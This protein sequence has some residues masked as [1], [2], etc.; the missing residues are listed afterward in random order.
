MSRILFEQSCK[1]AF[2]ESAHAWVVRVWMHVWLGCIACVCCILLCFVVCCVCPSLCVCVYVHVFCFVVCCVS[3]SVHGFV[4]ILMVCVVWCA[5]CPSLCMGL[6]PYLCFQ[7]KRC[8]CLHTY[9]LEGFLA[10]LRIGL[11][12][13]H[14]SGC[15]PCMCVYNISEWVSTRVTS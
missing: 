9:W 3:V 15:V 11:T 14:L 1:N 13:L 8:T 4:S 7:E 12:L 6:C 5:V 2:D 10:V